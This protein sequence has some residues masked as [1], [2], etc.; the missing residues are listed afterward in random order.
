MSYK[1]DKEKY[2]KFAKKCF[3]VINGKI[4]TVI[5]DS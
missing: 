2:S 4:N 1:F 3:K 5:K